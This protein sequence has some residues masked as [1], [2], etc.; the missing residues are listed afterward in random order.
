MSVVWREAD[1]DVCLLLHYMDST[2]HNAF[3]EAVH[4]ESLNIGSPERS[5]FHSVC[6]DEGCCIE[7]QPEVVCTV[8]VTRHAVCL[9]ILQVLYPQFHL[10]TSAI[11][12]VDG[13]R[14]V[15]P[16]LGHHKSYVGPFRTDLYLGND[17]LRVFP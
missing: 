9:E 11:A 2:E 7:E 15:V 17:A 1:F 13:L 8:G 6:Q 10:T 16:V 14:C 4:G 12:P 3:D 5:V